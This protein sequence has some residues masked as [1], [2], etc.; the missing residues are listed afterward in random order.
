MRHRL[1]W[2]EV[3][4]HLQRDTRVRHGN[5]CN[6]LTL[7]VAEQALAL[8]FPAS[9]RQFLLTVGWLDIDGDEIFGLGED[10]PEPYMNVISKTD[11]ERSIINL[12]MPLVVV[13]QTYNGNLICLD[14]A[15]RHADECPVL[16]VRFCPTADMKVIADSFAEFVYACLSYGIDYFEE[17]LLSSTGDTVE[18]ETIEPI[19]W[20]EHRQLHYKGAQQLFALYPHYEYQP[21]DWYG[22]V[23]RPWASDL[24]GFVEEAQRFLLSHSWCRAVRSLSLKKWI[25]GV[26]ALF[27]AEIIPESE[28]NADEAVWVIVGDLP[29]AYLD[30]PSVPTVREAID[31]YIGAMQEWVD[32]VREGKPVD[33]LIPVYYRHSFVPVPP[34][35]RFAEMLAVRLKHLEKIL[36]TE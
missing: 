32:A 24:E 23:E 10:L 12:P 28:G 33:E 29:P 20:Q 9:Y 8:Q 2:N 34:T 5:G 30:M 13:S 3:L 18:I 19:S 11:N 7:Q 16:F 15:N 27:Y 31:A 35:L 22:V 4:R 25:E 26:F 17:I 6:E 36:N 21:A 1:D 14:T